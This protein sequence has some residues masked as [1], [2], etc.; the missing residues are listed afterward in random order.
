MVS[1]A[2]LDRLR[3]DREPLLSMSTGEGQVDLAELVNEEPAKRTTDQKLQHQ[4]TKLQRRP[5]HSSNGQQPRDKNATAVAGVVAMWGT[6][7]NNGP[8]DSRPTCCTFSGV[9]KREARSIFRHPSV[10]NTPFEVCRG[11]NYVT[12]SL[13]TEAGNYGTRGLT[14]SCYTQHVAQFAVRSTQHSSNIASTEYK[15]YIYFYSSGIS[16]S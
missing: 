9:L 3:L 7:R 4:I 1:T 6:N 10:A 11:T 5:D 2:S 16:Y 12:L 8:L 13:F 15:R 14:S